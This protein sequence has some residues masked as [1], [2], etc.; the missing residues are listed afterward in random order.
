MNRRRYEYGVIRQNCLMQAKRT[1]LLG[2]IVKIEGANEDDDR[3]FWVKFLKDDMQ[4]WES[5]KFQVKKD[6]V[7]LVCEELWPFL[8][9]VS[10]QLERVKLAQ[11]RER[12][13]RLMQLTKDMVVGFYD[14]STSTVL[15]G[16][17][18]YIGMI[19]GVGRGYG[20]QLH[21]RELCCKLHL[22]LILRPQPIRLQNTLSKCNLIGSGSLNLRIN[23]KYMP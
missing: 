8:A 11:D 19:R 2:T 13:G 9:A 18:K 17:I 16:T 10:S 20:I 15:L 3:M 5:V 4:T 7:A 1:A 21:V 12:C 23:Y 6:D 14:N 22:Y